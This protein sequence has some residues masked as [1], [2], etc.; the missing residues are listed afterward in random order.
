[1][2]SRLFLR[3]C[4]HRRV[5]NPTLVREYLSASCFPVRIR[6]SPEEEFFFILRSSYEVLA[7]REP[8][9][10]VILPWIE[11]IRAVLFLRKKS[12]R[13]YA[14]RGRVPS[15]RSYFSMSAYP[16][17]SPPF[18][19]LWRLLHRA[20][21]AKLSTRCKYPLRY[22]DTLPEC[23][24]PSNLIRTFFRVSR[25]PEGFSRISTRSR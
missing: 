23:V 14:V 24:N 16:P 13:Y 15:R 5:P 12:P 8:T 20:G 25:C 17:A 11:G 3:L 7:R 1:M 2:D 6:N 4:F 10:R 9:G 21:S 22:A 18:K 19:D